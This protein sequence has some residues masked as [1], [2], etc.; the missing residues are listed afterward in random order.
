M[1]AGYLLGGTLSLL[2]Y[3][4]D[5]RKVASLFK[6]ML[7]KKIKNEEAIQVIYLLLTILVSVAIGLIP[8]NEAINGI[9]AFSVLEISG[10]TWG[11]NIKALIKST[12]ERKIFYRILI[13]LGKSLVATFIT[14]LMIILLFGNGPAVAYG[15]IY[16]LFKDINHGLGERLLNILFIIP[17]LI[18]DGLLYLVYICRNKTLKINFKGEFFENLLY[19]PLLNVYILG[20]YI[21]TVNFY[22]IENCEVVHYLKSY[23]VYQGKIDEVAI[24]DLVTIIYGVAGAA[25]VLFI[26]LINLK[27]RVKS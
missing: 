16:F 24:K 1:R 14:P 6:S 10:A 15:M 27:L 26:I 25:F 17:S 2:L 8:E 23:G 5:R 12:S 11:L 9:V 13:L 21:E 19:M 4:V 22:H 3:K 7:K 20:A 18:G